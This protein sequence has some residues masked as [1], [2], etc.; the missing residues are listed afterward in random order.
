MRQEAIIW[1]PKRAPLL[2]MEAVLREAVPGAWSRTSAVITPLFHA[3]PKYRTAE[4]VPARLRLV[5]LENGDYQLIHNPRD[6]NLDELFL[7]WPMIMLYHRI[8]EFSPAL[9]DAE[10]V[11]VLECHD[12]DTNWEKAGWTTG[13]AIEQF[14][15][16]KNRHKLMLGLPPWGWTDRVALQAG[17]EASAAA[18]AKVCGGTWEFSERSDGAEKTVEAFFSKQKQPIDDDMSRH[19]EV[20]LD[21]DTI[22]K[23]F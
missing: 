7:E 18:L 6:P 14:A 23:G 16:R 1:A 5:T 4:A 13:T 3:S 19:G 10:R 15:S 17:L 21:D 2:E 20:L 22:F 12:L 11:S 8:D 9:A